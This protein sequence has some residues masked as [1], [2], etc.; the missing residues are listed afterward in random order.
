VSAA[1]CDFAAAPSEI[2]Y[3]ADARLAVASFGFS[4]WNLTFAEA[5]EQI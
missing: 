2:G 1:H 4:P 3:V 5:I